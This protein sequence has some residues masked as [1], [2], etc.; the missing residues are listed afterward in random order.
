MDKILHIFVSFMIAQIDYT[1]AFMF[2][3]GKEL[4]DLAG[5]GT[6]EFAD[7]IADWIGILLAALY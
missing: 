6:A 1:L 7:L 5:H 3:L 2:G 4:W